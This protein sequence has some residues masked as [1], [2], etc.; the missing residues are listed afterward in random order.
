MHLVNV[1]TRDM[2]TALRPHIALYIAAGYRFLYLRAAL[3][4]MLWS[5]GCVR[6]C[7]R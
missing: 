1:L 2:A 6:V 7:V 5:C 3:D 4:T